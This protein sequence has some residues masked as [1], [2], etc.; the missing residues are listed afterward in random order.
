ML[1]G[2]KY[3]ETFDELNNGSHCCSLLRSMRCI[4][5]LIRNANDIIKFG[6]VQR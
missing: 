4:F 3:L 6:V 1:Y 5:K 2:K